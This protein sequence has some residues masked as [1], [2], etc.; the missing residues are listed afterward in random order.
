MFFSDSL[1]SYLLE[2]HTGNVASVINFFMSS[3]SRRS[4]AIGVVVLVLSGVSNTP[5]VVGALKSLICLLMDVDI[6]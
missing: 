3:Y 5:A 4:S 6:C 2:T 1:A